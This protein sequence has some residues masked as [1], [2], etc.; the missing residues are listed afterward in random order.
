MDRIEEREEPE[1]IVVIEP[2]QGPNYYRAHCSCGWLS[3]SLLRGH[4]EVAGAA[5]EMSGGGK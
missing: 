5:H 2:A 4:A 1:H 3:K